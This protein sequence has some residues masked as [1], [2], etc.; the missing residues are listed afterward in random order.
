MCRPSLRASPPTEMSSA[1]RCVP[2]CAE[3]W[4]S[5]VPGAAS[6]PVMLL[7]ALSFNSSSSL[8]RCESVSGSTRRGRPA[9][10]LAQWLPSRPGQS[11]SAPAGCVVSAVGSPGPDRPAA[12]LCR[13]AGPARLARAPGREVGQ[14]ERGQLQVGAQFPACSRR[15][16][17]RSPYFAQ[18]A[19][20]A[21]TLRH[22]QDDRLGQ[23]AVG[24]QRVTGVAQQAELHG[25]A[26]AVGVAASLADQRQVGVVE[27][28]VADQVIP[29][30]PAA[31]AGCPAPWPR[32]SS[33]A[34]CVSRPCGGTGRGFPG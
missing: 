21:R 32:G 11:R 1:A 5:A 19:G 16:T 14:A 8:A 23:L 18:L 17:S 26:E 28:V 2:A 29:G 25:E 22:P 10:W 13:S 31:Q 27:G 30:F 33:D 6:Q 3:S 12:S 15:V 9:D 4:V 7:P 34:A 24:S 20:S